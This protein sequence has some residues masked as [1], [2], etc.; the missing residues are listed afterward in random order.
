MAPVLIGASHL[1]NLGGMLALLGLMLIISEA[2]KGMS[3]HLRRLYKIFLLPSHL[4]P[5]D[6]L[7]NVIRMLSLC[8]FAARKWLRSKRTSL[9]AAKDQTRCTLSLS[10]PTDTSLSSNENML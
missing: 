7:A 10:R 2:A 9:A 3:E 1:A 4:L 6:M 5:V 8:C